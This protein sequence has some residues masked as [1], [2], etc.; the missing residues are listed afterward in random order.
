MAYVY[1]LM[2]ARRKLAAR[3]ARGIAGLR[4]GRPNRVGAR[5][6][7]RACARAARLPLP[8]V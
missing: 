8:G 4:V 5:R 6:P 2:A 3:L 1:I 7:E